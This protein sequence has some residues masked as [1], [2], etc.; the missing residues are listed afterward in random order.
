MDLNCLW[1]LQNSLQLSMSLPIVPQQ[2]AFVDCMQEWELHWKRRIC[3]LVEGGEMI[4]EDWPHKEEHETLK[5]KDIEIAA[6][7][8][9][10]LLAGGAR[11]ET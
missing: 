9:S 4:F 5:S 3:S 8:L 2:N 11:E 6:R 7:K 1:G 10:K